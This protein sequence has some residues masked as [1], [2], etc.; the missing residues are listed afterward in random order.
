MYPG[1]ISYKEDGPSISLIYITTW[2][3]ER[4]NSVD[5]PARFRPPVDAI[6]ESQRTGGTW[7]FSRPSFFAIRPTRNYHANPQTQSL[8]PRRL[9]PPYRSAGASIQS[10]HVT[11]ETITRPKPKLR[12]ATHHTLPHTAR[13]HAPHT[14]NLT[15]VGYEP[16]TFSW[17]FRAP[18][19]RPHRRQKLEGDAKCATSQKIW[20]KTQAGRP[21]HFWVFY[22]AFRP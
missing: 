20:A 5:G 19:T 8:R 4:W 21:K 3:K 18:T 14:P 15:D 9:H 2:K 12:I 22:G 16:A 13:C 17:P 6:S 7:V 10:P 11:S 1:G